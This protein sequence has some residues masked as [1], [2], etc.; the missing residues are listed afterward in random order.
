MNKSTIIQST[1]LLL[2][3]T[4]CGHHGLYIIIVES[5]ISVLFKKSIVTEMIVTEMIF[6][7]KIHLTTQQNLLITKSLLSLFRGLPFNVIFSRFGAVDLAFHAVHSHYQCHILIWS[8]D[9][10]LEKVKNIF[11]WHRHMDEASLVQ[12]FSRVFNIIDTEGSIHKM[13]TFL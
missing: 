10:L 8:S 7:N 3:K 5:V 12:Y 6:A 13:C 9:L 4:H 11:I 1:K 2:F